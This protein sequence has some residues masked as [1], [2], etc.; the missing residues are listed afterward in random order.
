MDYVHHI[1]MVIPLEPHFLVRDEETPMHPVRDWM[2]SDCSTC[3]IMLGGISFI[4]S[5]VLFLFKGSLMTFV[6]FM[7]RIGTNPDLDGKRFVLSRI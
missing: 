2:R 5:C 4:P 3:L 1:F 7:S 6:T